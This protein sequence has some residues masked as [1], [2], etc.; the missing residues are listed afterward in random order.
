MIW[1]SSIK[2]TFLLIINISLFLYA[3]FQGGFVSW[4]LFYSFIILTSITILSVF[5]S[6]RG[7]KIERAFSG[8]FVQANTPL[9]VK[10][11]LKKSRFQPFFYVI[12][13]DI[14]PIELNDSY[15]SPSSIFFFTLKREISF[16]YSIKKLPR[17]EYQ[18]K[19]VE[20]TLGDL[21]GFFEKRKVFFLESTVIVYP[22]YRN[23][24]DWQV[25]SKN[26][27]ESTVAFQR[28]LE[29]QLSIAGVRHYIAGDRLTSIDWKQSA[30]RDSL[31]TKEFETFKG[32]QYNICL[33]LGGSG[34]VERFEHAVELAASFSNYFI[35]KELNFC[36]VFLGDEIVV[37]KFQ[38]RHDEGKD[39]Y[40]ELAIVT[41]SE[42]NSFLSIPSSFYGEVVIIITI[43]LSSLNQQ[44]GRFPEGSMV[45]IC[46]IVPDNKT[47][48][49]KEIQ[50][51]LQQR[52][53]RLYQF[54]GQE[55]TFN[56]M[57]I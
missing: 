8:E 33:N 44:L 25:N 21:F 53:I 22:A 5:F 7:F 38:S 14:L 12:V 50:K 15:N 35:S 45:I 16:Q 49:E 11:T 37:R 1:K 28:A 4:F 56:E 29:E 23:L 43:S 24:S 55:T 54:T 46:W 51:Q 30:R 42:T 2:L 47:V 10:I 41:Q 57:T 26:Q 40:R 17:G 18:W 48:E 19:E 31:M 39:I 52:N 6:F 20:I 34:K 13:S 32:N 36:L 9:D 27:G 3:M